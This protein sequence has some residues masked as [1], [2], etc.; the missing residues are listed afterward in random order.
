MQESKSI[1]FLTSGGDSPGMNAAIRSIVRTA[2]HHGWKPYAIY[3]GFSGLID[4]N[5]KTIEWEDVT[6]I[7][8]QGGTVIR[9]SRC[10]EFLSKD[11]RKKAVLNLASRGIFNLIVIGGDGSLTGAE[12]LR[13]EWS[14]H[15]SQLIEEGHLASDIANSHFSIIGII[16]SIDNDMWGTEITIGSNSSLHRIIESLDNITAT[17]LSHARAFVIE[18][19]GRNCGWLALNAA[20]AIGADWVLI[21][22]KPPGKNWVEEMVMQLQ[23]VMKD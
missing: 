13:S 17:A 14:D 16:G 2:L 1:G 20:I 3:D 21:P 12:C 7:L 6:F 19:M 5:I 22:E 9:S 18:V 8:S 10:Q 11:W 15:I 23:K 4:G